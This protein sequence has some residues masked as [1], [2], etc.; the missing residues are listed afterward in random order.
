MEADLRCANAIQSMEKKLRAACHV[1]DAKLDDVVKVNSLLPSL[2]LLSGNINL[3]WEKSPIYRK[4]KLTQ[5]NIPSKLVMLNVLI[6]S[7][8]H[9]KVSKVH[10]QSPSILCWSMDPHQ[11]SFSHRT[12]IYLSLRL[13]WT[14]LIFLVQYIDSICMGHRSIW[15][16]Y[17]CINSVRSTV[18]WYMVALFNWR[19]SHDFLFAAANGDD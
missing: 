19:Q 6:S 9:F 10:L 17:G 2:L 5:S 14:N 15:L 16:I 18:L 7:H 8:N 1:P 4:K 3:F 13:Q 12:V 11:T